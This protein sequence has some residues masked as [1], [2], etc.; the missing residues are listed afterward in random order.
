MM[1]TVYQ[2]TTIDHFDLSS[3]FFGCVV[4]LDNGQADPAI[5]CTVTATCVNPA[6]KTVASQSFN[7]MSNGGL[8]QNMVEAKPSGFKGCQFV[9]F[10][11]ASAAGATTGTAM[12][13]F[14]Y[15]V[16]STLPLSP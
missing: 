4:G 11:T 12:D 6:G 1:T 7:F 10:V 3:F 13:T 5:S 14:T 9:S 2:D 15:T 16:Y 8:V